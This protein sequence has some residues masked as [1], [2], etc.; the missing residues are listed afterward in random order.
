MEKSFKSAQ[1]NQSFWIYALICYSK[2]SETKACY[3]GQTTNLHRRLKE[4][5]KNKRVGKSSFHLHQWTEKEKTKIECIVLCEIHGN[6]K[7]AASYEKYWT[8]LAQKDGFN[9]PGIENWGQSNLNPT[10]NDYFD[11]W[12]EEQI[13]EKLVDLDLVVSKEKTIQFLD[14]PHTTQNLD[15]LG[16][17]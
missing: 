16:L 6:Q 4:H 5:F 12:P 11:S 8:T 14:Q 13:G 17:F 9:T 1:E 2:N 7:E 10:Y 3:I 15:Q